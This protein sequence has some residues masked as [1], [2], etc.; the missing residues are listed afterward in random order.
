MMKDDRF[1]NSET[2]ET[3][4]TSYTGSEQK[5]GRTVDPISERSVEA[6]IAED[7]EHPIEDELNMHDASFRRHYQL[8]YSDQQLEYESFYAP[9]YR[10]GYQLS[11]THP[12]DTWQQV[13][14]QAERQ[15]SANHSIDWN[16]IA[17]AVKYGWKEERNPDEV[18]VNHDRGQVT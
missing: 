3:V 15:W 13:E 12:N 17:E 2:D 6:N 16:Q 18:R 7:H 11:E 10:Y 1:N 8:N 4:Y 9:A 5:T 14:S